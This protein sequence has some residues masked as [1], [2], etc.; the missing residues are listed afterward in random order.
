[1]YFVV[2]YT[3]LTTRKHLHLSIPKLYRCI[4]HFFQV[5]KQ[6]CKLF[7]SNRYFQIYSIKSDRLHNCWRFWFLIVGLWFRIPLW[8]IFFPFCSSRFLGV[9][10]YP[11]NTLQKKKKKK[12]K[13]K[14]QQNNDILILN[15][16]FSKGMILHV[17]VHFV[18]SL[19]LYQI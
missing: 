18:C 16:V 13:K 1:M 15:P 9:P 5:Q 6:M 14:K 10:R 4:Y 2:Y 11:T 17:H 19:E 3:V 12:K 8:A 7:I